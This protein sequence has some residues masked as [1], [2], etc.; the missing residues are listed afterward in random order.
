MKNFWQNNPVKVESYE[1]NYRFE[2]ESGHEV[3][4]IISSED[5]IITS[6]DRDLPHT[7]ISKTS[8]YIEQVT[9]PEGDVIDVD[10]DEL[11]KFLN[12]QL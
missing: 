1:K 7:F 10:T 8:I 11:A 4:A 6:V 9:N 12:T 2:F 5:T 3:E